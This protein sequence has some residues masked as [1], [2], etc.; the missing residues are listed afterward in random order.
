[1]YAAFR[2]AAR[3]QNRV[4]SARGERHAVV[5][6]AKLLGGNYLFEGARQEE[7]EVAVLEL[8]T[9]AI[10]VGFENKLRLVDDIDPLGQLA[11]DL[12]PRPFRRVIG[13]DDDIGGAPFNGLSVG[14]RGGLL[15][16][17]LGIVKHEAL[18]AGDSTGVGPTTLAMSEDR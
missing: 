18:L 5:H 16:V 4:L 2:N 17:G 10:G 7:E 8:L 15:E 3:P 14:K 12:F 9:N 13:D 11:S 1:M 6:G